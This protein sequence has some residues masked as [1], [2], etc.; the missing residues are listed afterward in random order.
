MRVFI[1]PP[2][3][4]CG[5]GVRIIFIAVIFL[6]AGCTWSAEHVSDDASLLD[7]TD[8]VDLPPPGFKYDEAPLRVAIAAMTSPKE[9]FVYYEELLHYLGEHLDRPIRMEQR[10]TYQEVND[11]LELEAI[12][13]AFICTGAYLTAREEFPVH[14]LG[15]PVIKGRNVYNAYIIA[16]RNVSVETFSDLRGRSFA[17]TDPLS[18]SGHHF[19]ASKLRE[20]GESPE[21]FFSSTVFSGGHDYSILSV[22]NGVVDAA[23]VDGLVFEYMMSQQPEIL[24]NVKVITVSRDFGMPPIVMHG[25]A[26]DSLKAA[27][28]DILFSMHEDPAGAAILKPLLI[29]RFQEARVSDY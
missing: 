16:N 20:M 17:F 29:D 21:H 13:L 12:E 11:L 22:A 10:K 28:S 6:M 1:C 19:L 25:A 7:L 8:T 18:N 15:V 26:S 9:T 3:S 23:T 24:R 4:K 27:I 5:S 2:I 14:L